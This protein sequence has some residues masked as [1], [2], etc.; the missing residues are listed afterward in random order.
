MN[1]LLKRLNMENISDLF[2]SAYEKLSSDKE[3]PE[4]LTESYVRT[5]ISDC[6]ISEEVL[7]LV[8]P[9]LPLVR[10][11]DDLVLFS[12]I[13]YDM[14]GIHKHHSEVFGGLE[15]PKAPEGYNPLPYD[16]FSFFP[17]LARVRESFFKLKKE[18]VSEE[19]L[20]QTYC[21]VGASIISSEAKMGRTCFPTLYFLWT[22]TYKNADLFTIGRF[23][24]EIRRNC[25]LK[26]RAFVNKNGEIK[27]L[28]EDGIKV[29]ES[30][31]ISG[32]AGA[33]DDKNSFETKYCETEEYFEG[34]PVTE[35]DA[36][37]INEKIQLK[38]SDWKL[39][40]APGDNYISVHIP[41]NGTFAPDV[42]ES[43]IN[44]G[45]EFM[46]KLYPET[47]FK[48]FMCISWLLSPELKQ[49]LKPTSNIISF[50]NRYNK[51]PVLC[52]GLDI[53]NFVFGKPISSLSEVDFKSLSEDSSL[54]KALKELYISGGFIHETGGIFPF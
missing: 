19:I 34:N 31:L 5:A 25:D 49:I 4:W 9:A 8:L 43:S 20:K 32:S 14:L 51:F 18:G 35:S 47:D 17:M 42:V 11:N 28:M 48:A 38:K 1:D 44:S 2:D 12:K 6:F 41:G 23:N 50:Q 30:G 21:S 39:L 29:H 16:L 36:R 54:K 10:E 22:T 37:I 26:M 52:S 15:F 13:L 33:K 7:N 46:K 3:I 53:F 45:R 24:F 40:C 27:I